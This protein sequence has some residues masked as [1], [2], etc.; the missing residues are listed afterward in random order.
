MKTQN[1]LRTPRAGRVAELHVQ[2]GM[3]IETGS[4]LLRLE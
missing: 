4:K 2:E 3:G 1:E